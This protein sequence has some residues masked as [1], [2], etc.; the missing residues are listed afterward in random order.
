MAPAGVESQ[1]EELLVCLAI[2]LFA[3]LPARV[4]ADAHVRL[5]LE[6]VKARDQAIRDGLSKRSP[7]PCESQVHWINGEPDRFFRE[8]YYNACLA[9]V[10]IGLNDP[11]IC[12]QAKVKGLPK[13]ESVAPPCLK[14]YF[15]F[16]GVKEA[17]ANFDSV[18]PVSACLKAAEPTY[19]WKQQ[20]WRS[21]GSRW[22]SEAKN[23][24]FP[25]TQRS[26]C[27]KM[28]G[29]WSGEDLPYIGDCRFPAE[30][31]GKK[32]KDSSQCISLV[33]EYHGEPKAKNGY[34]GTCGPIRAPERD[35]WYLNPG[36][37]VVKGVLH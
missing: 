9:S 29:S 4:T 20:L 5:D 1:K 3:L 12:I 8:G 2:A 18:L 37:H 10:A 17:C 24:D 11:Q 33:C 34:A 26:A 32:C 16:Y 23:S 21:K 7:S 13:P 36:A 28:G 6:R 19:D 31:Q 27:E 15:K 25:P 14:T 22:Q 30:D 35:I